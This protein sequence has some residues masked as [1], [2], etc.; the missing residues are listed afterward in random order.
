MGTTDLSRHGYS[1]YSMQAAF[2]K[3]RQPES[4]KPLGNNNRIYHVE[5]DR[6]GI[7]YRLEHYNTPIFTRYLSGTTMIFP[8][9]LDSVT[10]KG[11]LRDARIAA[12]EER[13]VAYLEVGGQTFVWPTV[14][15]SYATMLACGGKLFRQVQTK[16]T[17]QSFRWELEYIQELPVVKAVA[18][19]K[20]PK[21]RNTILRPKM[22]DAFSYKDE[23]YIWIRKPHTMSRGLSKVM[24][25]IK[26]LGDAGNN[27]SWVH[28]PYTGIG[29][30]LAT[31]NDDNPLEVMLWASYA[32][33]CTA[34]ERFE[35][36]ASQ[37][38]RLKL[39]C[40]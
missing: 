11:R 32:S 5:N 8:G 37:N 26:Y 13:D 31:L 19:R 35:H 34:I 17:E 10:S 4:G 21:S 14:K 2:A 29:K 40:G 20:L 6:F 30:P 15:Y 36:D 3:A 16:P 33:D 38:E 23:K 25:A 24:M 7:G 1:W 22:G 28:I 39:P 12:Y 9:S 27:R 18:P